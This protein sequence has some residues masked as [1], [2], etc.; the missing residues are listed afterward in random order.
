M[1]AEE[2][3]SHGLSL[4]RE[5]RFIEAVDA[6]GKAVAVQ[7]DF[8]EGYYNL[9]KALKDAGRLN[10]AAGAYRRTL[11]LRPD[12]AAAWQNL[13][14][15]LQEIGRNGEAVAAYRRVVELEANNPGAHGMLARLLH[16]GG[17]VEESIDHFRALA[18]LLPG[19]AEVWHALG[20]ALHD[21][22]RLDEAE[23]AYR[24]C[25]AIEPGHAHAT[26][27]VG[28]I[29]LAR[30]HFAGGWKGYEARRR[31]PGPR[32]VRELG[33]RIWDGESLE[34]Q[35]IL[36][37]AEQ[38]LGDT[39]QFIR[40]VPMVTQRGGRVVVQCP[41]ALCRLL[42][43]QLTIEEVCA[44]GAAP[45]AFD[46]H[47]PLLSLPG[48][49]GTTVET[50]PAAVPYLGADAEAVGRWGTKLAP[51]CGGRRRVGVVWSGS[52]GHRND[53]NRSIPPAALE[54][55]GEVSNV[56][57][58]NLQIGGSGPSSSLKYSMVDLTT[59]LID[60]AETSAAIANLDLVIAV[61]TAVAHLA[62][63]MGK[64]V[65]VLVPYA[66]DW[67]W[68]LGREDSPWYPTMRLYRQM[69]T[70]EWREPLERIARDLRAMVG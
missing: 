68:L 54:F 3:N 48:V 33:G 63:A 60:M 62:A 57:W 65:W 36:L 6:F 24:A 30:G 59:E 16:Q 41:A 40:Y 61:D 1:T 13:G 20:V 25:L 10:E 53:R 8:T 46:V 51:L 49:F 31:L 12:S 37:H 15:V 21:L 58:V 22:N 45:P 4:A 43:G 66:A 32:A 27:A 50:I 39:I 11:E 26:Y 2:Y 44:D 18:R 47:C 29:Q 67:R 9:G 19:N 5:G 52:P 38:G 56:A 23:E 17:R 70:G 34:G 7:R 28:L 55:L 14:N 42:G 64:P 69:A 35:R